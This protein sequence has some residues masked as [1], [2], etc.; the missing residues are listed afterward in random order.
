MVQP[1]IRL[2]RE[3]R[4]R[5]VFRTGALYVVGA[6]LTLQV[7]NVVFP[8]FGIP[9]SAIRGLIWA[10][11]LGFPVALAFG[12]LFEIGAGGIRR[13][14]PAD[15][16]STAVPQP[17]GRRDYLLLAAFAAI[18]AV[19]VYRA[20]QD[21]R[22]APK[23]AAMT[24]ADAARGEDGHRL[25]NSIAVL[26]FTNISD[27]P[28]NEYFCD[29]IAEEILDRLARAAGLKVIG[30]TSSFAFKGS[31]Y[32]IERISTLLGVHYVL[33]GSVRKAGDQLRVSAQLLDAKGLQVW[34]ES[35]DRQLKNVF[36]IQ[37]EIASAVASTV[38]SQ[39]VPDTGGHE[40]NLDAYE[41]YLAGRTLL[42]ARDSERAREELQRAVALDPQFA[43]AHAELAITQ[44]LEETPE[45][46][47]RARVSV[48]RALQL[49]PKLVRAHAAEGL[50]LTKARP[51]DLAG[52]ERV[53]REV[54]D[55]DP[56]MSDALNW[57]Q[58]V[59]QEQGRD[60]EARAILERA[61]VI[62][63]LHPAI[64]ANLAD[65][66]NEEGEPE[67]AM[68]IYERAMEQPNPSPMIFGAAT[69][70]YRSTGR[71]IELSTA[72]KRA[73]LRDPTASSLFF[74]LLSYSVL[75]DWPQVEAVN[76]RLMRATPEGPGRLF[77]A[78]IL[79]SAKG[80][81]DVTVQRLREVLSERRM[82]LADL[83][84]LE[85]LIAGVHL[86]R[87]GDYAAAIEALEPV[88][89]VEFPGRTVIPGSFINGAHAL[90]F[91]YM[92]T[93]ADAKATACW[94]PKHGNAAVYE[95]TAVSETAS[96]CIGA[97]RLNC[98]SAMSSRRSPVWRRQSRPGGATITCTSGTH[99]GRPWRAILAIAP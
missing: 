86:A 30:R 31:N 91:S 79:P 50:L 94:L 55:Q 98:C 83:N 88:V 18:A 16:E 93:G 27:D 64:A 25:E 85:R 47:G 89:D 68:R 21:V 75:G 32:G 80:Q 17:L 95:P 77:R 10:V 51:P 67:Q 13:T 63:P 59:L 84:E 11:G 38:A 56:N 61:A 69:R 6:W 40:P 42:H 36:E 37:S 57:L 74:L 14:L 54:L 76:E 34:S 58:S 20:A 43:E 41:H 9:D 49:K 5:K 45:A 15:A 3:A 90:A 1:V 22:E 52:A 73:A 19:L 65:L 44:V 92:H 29:G 53:L 71:L 60:D 4:R 97:P 96:I 26:P 62:D 82:T 72:Q 87:G 46:L 66:L 39:V 81:T 23:V 8:G 78:L 2:F 35:F 48:D 28:A 7:A 24:Q 33:Q 70:F 12:W 99:C